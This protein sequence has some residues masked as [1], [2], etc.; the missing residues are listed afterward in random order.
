MR[1]K[2]VVCVQVLAGLD[3]FGVGGFSSLYFGSFDEVVARLCRVLQ[4]LDQ[5]S[6]EVLR[7]RSRSKIAV[8]AATLERR[9]SLVVSV[10]V[11][12]MLF[13]D[14]GGGGDGV[15]VVL[16]NGLWLVEVGVGEGSK[17]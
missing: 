6:I 15:W 13:G 12:R 5:V 17:G 16:I 11:D 7:H 1:N 14:Y 3:G 2:F 10:S 4:S 9:Q 8:G